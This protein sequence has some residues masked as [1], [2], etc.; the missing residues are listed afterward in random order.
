M[1]LVESSVV[2]K[3]KDHVI[4]VLS[5]QLSEDITYHSINHTQDVVRSANEIA[6]KQSFSEAEVEILNIAAWFHDVGY[7]K[8][9]ENHEEKGAELARQF[10]KEIGFPLDGIEKVIGCILATKMPQTPSNNL[11]KTL[12][13][14]DLMHLAGNDYFNKAA[15][16]HKEIE[17]TKSCKIPEEQWLAMNEDFLDKHCFFTDYAKGRYESAVKENL[18]KV[19]E[20]LQTWQKLKK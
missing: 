1:M 10:L 13:D 18:R 15:L 3:V 17:K 19:K 8:G 16:L 20:R 9:N 12:C 6:S 5:D 2:R 7:T 11:E 14:A 4:K